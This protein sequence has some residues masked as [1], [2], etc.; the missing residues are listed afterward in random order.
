M[1]N[2]T[3]QFIEK[4]AFTSLPFNANYRPTNGSSSDFV[5]SFIIATTENNQFDSVQGFLTPQIKSWLN[6]FSRSESKEELYITAIDNLLKKVDYLNLTIELDQELITEDEFDHELEKNEDN[7]LITVN[8]NFKPTDFDLV[9]SITNRL[10]NRKFS[11]DEIS[12][13]FSIDIEKVEEFIDYH[14]HKFL[15]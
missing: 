10:K 14:N 2:N 11:S 8:Q 13:L 12:E 6:G 4:E 5:G 15:L 1:Q 3:S 7:Y 9:V